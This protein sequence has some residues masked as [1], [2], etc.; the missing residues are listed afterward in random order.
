MQDRDK[1]QPKNEGKCSVK[2]AQSSPRQAVAARGACT[3]EEE[4]M[5]RMETVGMYIDAIMNA[6]PQFADSDSVA[7]MKSS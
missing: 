6:L 7:E 1:G 3:I 5:A 4:G 2:S